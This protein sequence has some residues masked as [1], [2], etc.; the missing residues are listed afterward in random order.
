MYNYQQEHFLKP[1]EEPSEI[2][3]DWTRRTVYVILTET[4]GVVGQLGGKIAA[5]TTKS[6]VEKYLADPASPGVSVEDAADIKLIHGLVLD[7]KDLPMVLDSKLMKD[8][9]FWVLVGLSRY[10]IMVEECNDIDEVIQTVELVVDSEEIDI[11]DI[12]II[13]GEEVELALT[14][15]RAGDAPSSYQVYG[16]HT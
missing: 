4:S 15:A 14:P 10:N 8:K 13:L 3:K 1:K 16:S 11:E 2:N 5:L 9:T 12:C 6:D 7:S